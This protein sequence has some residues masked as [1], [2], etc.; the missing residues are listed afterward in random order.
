MFDKDQSGDIK[1]D[2]FL[3]LVKYLQLNLT[4]IQSLRIFSQSA[5]ADGF[6]DK[7]EFEKAMTLLRESIAKQALHLMGMSTF[8]LG[9]QLLV[10]L[11]I[12]MALFG[13]IFLGIAA[14]TQGTTF[15][16]V[17]NSFMSVSAALGLNSNGGVPDV[18]S[19]KGEAKDVVKKVFNNIKKST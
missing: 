18:N 2:E 1:F 4:E 19:K 7:D 13:F 10:R 16:S 9:I 11:V 17:V 3:D 6:L 8:E 12:L 14:F 5:K 15:E